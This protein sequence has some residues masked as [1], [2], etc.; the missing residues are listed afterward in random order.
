MS[1]G[2]GVFEYTS[3]L[4][5]CTRSMQCGQ[6]SIVY[7]HSKIIGIGECEIDVGMKNELELIYY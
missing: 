2:Q 5:G 4:M 3:F 1:I 7:V 6:F